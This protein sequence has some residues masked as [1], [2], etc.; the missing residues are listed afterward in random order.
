MEG[1]REMKKNML[2]Y[3]LVGSVGIV[4]IIFAITGKRDSCI[5]F[6]LF[7]SFY[8]NITWDYIKYDLKTYDP[9]LMLKTK[10]RFINILLLVIVYSYLSLVRQIQL[11]EVM[12]VSSILVVIISNILPFYYIYLSK[13]TMSS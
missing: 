5:L 1:C 3:L 9:E 2:K 4:G 10:N 8:S 11:R 6:L 13:R 7:F 12:I